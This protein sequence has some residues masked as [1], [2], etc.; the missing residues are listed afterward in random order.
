MLMIDRLVANPRRAFTSLWRRFDTWI[1]RRRTRARLARR[2]TPLPTAP[3]GYVVFFT[4][5]AGVLPHYTAQLVLA[6]TL[7]T[8]GHPIA[9]VRCFRCLTRC[10]VMDLHQ[11][12]V[13]RTPRDSEKFCLR[14]CG[15]A[16][17][18]LDEYHLTN[19]D[20]RTLQDDTTQGD[21]DAALADP[22]AKLLDF[23]FDGKPFGK[24]CAFDL[25]LA[26]KVANFDA[27]SVQQRQ[28]WQAYIA[29]S[30]EAYRATQ[31]LIRKHPVRRIVCFN[32]YSVFLGVRLAAEE[33]GVPVMTTTLA[34]HCNIDRRK[35]VFYKKPSTMTYVQQAAAWPSWRGLALRPQ[36]VSDIGDD[37]FERFRGLGSHVY[38]TAKTFV[39][40]RL[41]DTLQL[42]PGK[43]LLVAYTSSLDEYR[44][45][46]AMRE[47]LH[48][49]PLSTDTPFVNQI[50]WLGALISDTESR[51]DR[52]LVIRIH[53][54]EGV[55]K[56]ER[57]ASQHL[58]QLRAEFDKP[59]RNCRIIWPEDPISSYDLAELADVALT[60]WSSIGLELARIGVP[61][62][63]C[64]HSHM[65]T[66]EED[67]LNWGQTPQAYFAKVTE[68]L[69]RQPSLGPIIRAFRW[70]NLIYLG[71]SLDLK[72][73]IPDATYDEVPPFVLP[74][75]ARAIEQVLVEGRDVLEINRARLEAEQTPDSPA[76]EVVAIRL[77]LRRLIELAMT[78]N[79]P[80]S[81]RGL[82]FSDSNQE[83]LGD[84]TVI[85][86]EGSTVRM[87]R[88]GR[89]WMRDSPLV[90]RLVP[91]VAET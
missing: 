67:F 76:L 41:R 5:E 4:P 91:L 82:S 17:R 19:L 73:L 58:L 33:L 59:Y 57:F 35:Y 39:Q 13:E 11:V 44:A 81:G 84:G 64:A 20:L 48:F 47:A 30:I 3:D 37:I 43:K 18:L 49:E 9:F 78:G 71:L 10:P 54:R 34:S 90:S 83:G 89:T 74:R 70:Y 16:F 66:P 45:A 29:A 55:N 32:D 42:H 52:N 40:S 8:L 7:Q 12:P 56:R 61:V 50:E 21:I 36:R 79:L 27:L 86:C 75:E 65:K 87:S 80:A 51:G 62:V 24:L 46:V 26:C 25:V 69:Q 28:L 6:K 53:P 63:V 1:D 85:E 22:A 60:S 2:P 14:C 77:F 23:S 15:Q 68:V 72:D 38:S 31:N 88:N